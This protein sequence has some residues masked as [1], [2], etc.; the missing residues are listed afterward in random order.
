M[1]IWVIKSQPSLNLGEILLDSTLRLQHQNTKC[2]IIFWKN[3]V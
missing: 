1:A 2:G 3:G